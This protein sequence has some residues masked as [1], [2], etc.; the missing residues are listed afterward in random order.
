[1]LCIPKPGSGDLPKLR[2]VVDLRERNAN[3]KKM[4]SPLPDMEGILRWAARA[5]F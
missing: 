3:R 4:S 2:T 5:N 1:M